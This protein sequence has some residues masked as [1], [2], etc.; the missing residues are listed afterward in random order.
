MKELLDSHDPSWV[1]EN[2]VPLAQHFN[3]ESDSDNPYYGLDMI[4]AY[5][6]DHI[7]PTQSVVYPVTKGGVMLHGNTRYLINKLNILGV[8]TRGIFVSPSETGECQEPILSTDVKLVPSLFNAFAKL[9]TSDMY[10]RFAVTL[11]TIFNLRFTDKAEDV[12]RAVYSE[13]HKLNMSVPYT[14]KEPKQLFGVVYRETMNEVY[15]WLELNNS[16]FLHNDMTD[17]HGK[18]LHSSI[19]DTFLNKLDAIGTKIDNEDEVYAMTEDAIAWENVVIWFHLGYFVRHI[20]EPRLAY[21]RYLDCAP[22]KSLVKDNYADMLKSAQAKSSK[23]IAG[24]DLTVIDEISIPVTSDIHLVTKKPIGVV[25]DDPDVDKKDIVYAIN[26]I[27]KGKT[28]STSDIS[29][30]LSQDLVAMC[31]YE[32]GSRNF[33]PKA[34]DDDE[35]NVKYYYNMNGHKF[36]LF[37]IKGYDD[38]VYGWS[39]EAGPRTLIMLSG[40]NGYDYKF[41]DEECKVLPEL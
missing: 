23:I 5:I 3:L 38:T 31:T 19:I 9:S 41:I 13:L 8:K 12:I 36:I 24:T 6:A 32:Y 4:A 21:T 29:F 28:I 27:M 2:V 22:F 7:E 40:D 11:C 20:K 30:Y 34:S 33:A 39:I 10:A 16:L 15:R 18:V 26:R 25:V 17:N 1:F 35:F 37:T 14:T